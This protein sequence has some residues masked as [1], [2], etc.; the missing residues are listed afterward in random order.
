MSGWIEH[1]N[2]CRAIPSGV[3]FLLPQR[4][5]MKDEQRMIEHCGWHSIP[6]SRDGQ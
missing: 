4:L 3:Q 6:D 5:L 2:A 1:Y